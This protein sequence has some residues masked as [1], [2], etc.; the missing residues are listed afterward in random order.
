[1]L[2]TLPLDS[3]TFT[4]RPLVP[5]NMSGKGGKGMGKM[6]RLQMQ[7]APAAKRH[8]KRVETYRSYTTK[9]IRSKLGTD[10][11]TISMRK[12]SS[13]IFNHLIDNVLDRVNS[14]ATRFT[15]FSDR[16]TL[17]QKHIEGAVDLLFSP[18]LA[19]RIKAAS[20]RAVTRFKSEK[21]VKDA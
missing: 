11:A 13:S 8:K 12:S 3:P 16:K 10:E 6:A 2:I 9:V 14:V 19:A 20:Q 1:M 4:I 21:N 17:Q 18:E 7:A 15:R 5:I